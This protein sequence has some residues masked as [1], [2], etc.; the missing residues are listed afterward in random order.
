VK[1]YDVVGIGV[2][3]TDI[4]LVNPD[5]V[6]FSLETSEAKK[7]Y[8]GLETGSKSPSRIQNFTGGSSAN[9]LAALAN[10]GGLKLGYVGVVGT[11]QYSSILVDDLEHRGID[12]SGVIRKH[13]FLSGVSI[14]LTGGGGVRDRAISV[15]HGTGE[16]L[17]HRDLVWAEEI[18]SAA[19]WVDVTSL[20]GVSIQ[21]VRELLQK[22]RTNDDPIKVFFAPSASMIHRNLPAIQEW[23]SECDALA[24]NDEE[25]MLLTE[26]HKLDE[27]FQWLTDHGAPAT[28]ITRGSLG[29]MRIE[30][31][32]V[33]TIGVVPLKREQIINTTGAGDI[34][35]AFFIL[36]LLEGSDPLHTMQM[37]AVAGALKIS[38]PELGAKS[39]LP[40]RKQIESELSKHKKALEPRTFNPQKQDSGS[41]HD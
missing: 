37:A 12:V 30:K 40:T 22:L 1:K 21:P 7:T 28:F 26:K 25:L 16:H 11:D 6:S 32:N 14:I 35:A 19:K 15:D 3:V 10:L 38:S 34:S 27:C 33:M 17:S 4:F 2:P 13:G 39:G 29:I 31:Q 36:G 9:S 20:P 18:I 5:V 24:M 23:V 8:V 41:S